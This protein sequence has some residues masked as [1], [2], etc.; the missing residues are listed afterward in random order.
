MYSIASDFS[1]GNSVFTYYGCYQR[2]VWV[3]GVGVLHAL[4][5][6]KLSV[7]LGLS[8]RVEVKILACR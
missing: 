8:V 3:S 6:K 7:I 5:L 2:R 1:P 4:F